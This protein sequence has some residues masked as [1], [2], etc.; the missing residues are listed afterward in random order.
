MEEAA[1]VIKIMKHERRLNR[2]RLRGQLKLML[3][4]TRRK[5]H[6]A[7]IL[8]MLVAQFVDRAARD[9]SSA[10]IFEIFSHPWADLGMRA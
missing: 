4:P 8:T 9:Y 7:M 5:K 2:G 6:L 1:S 10:W 3:M